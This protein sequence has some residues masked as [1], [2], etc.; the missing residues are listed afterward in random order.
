MGGVHYNG[1]AYD[2]YLYGLNYDYF[3]CFDLIM[4]SVRDVLIDVALKIKQRSKAKMVV[5]PEPELEHFTSLSPGELQFKFIKL[6]NTADAIAVHNEETIPFFQALTRK[7]VGFVG[8]PFPLK[9]LREELCPQVQNDEGEIHLG[10]LM[11]S[12][13]NRNGFANLAVLS[14]T[15][16]P[17]AV[18]IQHPIE[19]EYIRKV[20][21]YL[22]IPSIRCHQSLSWDHYMVEVSKSTLGVHLDFRLTW[23]RFP[24]DCAALGIPCV[25]SPN[26]Y[27]QKILFPRLCVPC[28]D[29]DKAAG[30]VRELYNNYN[31][32]DEVMA[33]A[34]SKLPMFSYEESKK[35]LLNLV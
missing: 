35:R 22:Q 18:D 4:V 11:G 34:E 25:A 19:K 23:G 9:R 1:I 7:P 16:L 30:L 15:G 14:K 13:I 21:N 32:Y 20:R 24:I 8:L 28:Q 10:S 33:F 12:L 6:L 27:T 5:F 26:L 17:G 3:D 29:I 31:F 2:Q